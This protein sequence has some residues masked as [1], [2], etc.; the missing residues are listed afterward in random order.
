M[1]TIEKIKN[2]IEFKPKHAVAII[3]KTPELWSWILTNS[4]PDCI[5][6]VSQVYTAI[7]PTEKVLCPCGSKIPRKIRSLKEGFRFCGPAG[8]CIAAKEL[9]SKK[10]VEKAKTWDKEQA[11]KRRA[12]TNLEK[13]GV[14]NAGQTLEAIQK[15]K[16]FYADPKKVQKV[17]NQIA[18][19]YFER[20]GYYN[21]QQNPSVKQ[22][23]L[24]FWKKKC[25]VNNAMQVRYDS[26][27]L[28]LLENPKKFADLLTYFSVTD[29][30]QLLNCSRTTV[31]NYHNKHGLDLLSKSCYEDEL[32]LFFKNEGINYIRNDRKILSGSE[33]DFF[34]PDYNL[35]I[36]VGSLYWHAEYQTN[37]VCNRK[38]HQQKMI[39]CNEKSIQLLTIFGDEWVE[40]KDIILKHI[41]HLCKQSPKVIGARKLV[42]KE[43]TNN[44]CYEFLEKHHIQGGLTTVRITIGA[45]DQN[46]TLVGVVCLRKVKDFEYDLARF[47]TDFNASYPGL[48]SKFL[49]YIKNNYRE[50]KEITT[51]ADLRW[52]C[53]DVYLKTGFEKDSDTPPCYFY[54]DYKGRYHR[55]NFRK[56]KLASRFGVDISNKTEQQIT[57]ELGFDRIWDCGKIKF[58]KML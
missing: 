36:K 9:V 35:A 33:L 28:D 20:T 56:E 50:V 13:Y 58:R 44:I 24:N 55:F 27:T 5:D 23:T 34:L 40:R 43:I 47:A 16:A 10:C 1:N 15:H 54:T 45:F 25:G 2:L 30:A 29:L 49:N 11:R 12:K 18:Q 3:K 32:T 37:G 52:S 21:P 51:F 53:G 31:I 8:K 22:K 38:Y 39:K 42:V 19:T 7:N 48:F 17:T 14:A 57:S 6:V 4:D 26:G 41:L 46:D